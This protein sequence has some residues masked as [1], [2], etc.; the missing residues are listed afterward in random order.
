MARI[1]LRQ[2]LHVA[3]SASAHT[4]PPP[5][6][7][8][9]WRE[10]FGGA[11]GDRKMY[12]QFQVSLLVGED[13]SSDN[14]CFLLLFSVGRFQIDLQLLKWISTLP[15]YRTQEGRWGEGKKVDL[16]KHRMNNEFWGWW[17]IELTDQWTVLCCCWLFSPLGAQIPARVTSIYFSLVV[18]ASWF[19]ERSH[20]GWAG[21]NF[22]SLLTVSGNC[23]STYFFFFFLPKLT[24][25][26]SPGLKEQKMMIIA[27]GG[28]K[29]TWANFFFKAPTKCF[30]GHKTLSK[31]SSISSL[32]WIL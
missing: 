31:M 27:F 16:D 14:L 25:C 7:S 19:P 17:I 23:K 2:Y 3:C 21:Q 15:T 10:E 4:P 18:L 1:Q 26:F 8:Q 30:P 11:E 22:K 5:L 24:G 13:L 28:K 6:T 29:W 9:P 12:Q 20:E 32:C